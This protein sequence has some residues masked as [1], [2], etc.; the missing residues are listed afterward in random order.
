MIA[1]DT[2]AILAILLSEPDGALF[3]SAIM[4]E[5]DCRLSAANLLEM[6]MVL[7][8]RDPANISDLDQFL[9][10]MDIEIEPVTEYQSDLAFAAFRSFGKGMGHPAGLNF[11]D[12]LAYALARSHAC[13]LLFKGNDFSQTDI[14][15]AI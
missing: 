10:R 12:C 15:S 2:S 7:Y 11:G 9:K 6:R 5:D 1:I 8:A 4:S 3:L 14:I 13:P